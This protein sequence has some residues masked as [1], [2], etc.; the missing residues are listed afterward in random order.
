V[1]ASD[2]KQQGDDLLTSNQPVSEEIRGSLESRIS[3]MT[4]PEKV[5]LAAKGNREVRR[6]LSRDTSVMVARAL[7][8]SP[9]LSDEDIISFAS[10]SQTNED[11]LRAIAENRQWTMNRQVVTAIVQN[12][13]TPPPA[14]IRF[15][16]GFA[17]NELRVLSNNR[18]VSVV[19]RQEAKRMLTQR[20]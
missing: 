5:E 9:L 12:P 7:I 1:T 11:I 19:V 10:S 16:R 6:I 8:S 17:T 2:N 20:N 4:V 3:A 14:A 18:S 13:R 15:L